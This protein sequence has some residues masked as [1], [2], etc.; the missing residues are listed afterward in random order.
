MEKN[1]AERDALE[2]E[3]GIDLNGYYDQ[4]IIEYV[5]HPDLFGASHFGTTQT[6]SMEASFYFN[7]GTG[8]AFESV[9]SAFLA[10]TSDIVLEQ[11]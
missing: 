4:Y 2:Y 8:A 6:Q 9:I 11:I 1:P 10:G 5:T 3:L 7:E